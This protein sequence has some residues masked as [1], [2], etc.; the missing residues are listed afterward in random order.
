M[1]LVIAAA[2]FLCFV[3]LTVTT[4]PG[5]LHA[6]AVG[7]PDNVLDRI[8]FRLIGPNAPS[9]RVWNVAGVPSRPKAFYVCTAQGGVFRTSN[10]GTTMEPVF[11]QENAASC[12]A[13]AIA[14]SDPQCIWVGSGEPAARQSNGLGY[15]AYKSTDGGKTWQFLGL[16]NTEQIAAIA[17]HPRDPQ[18][19]WLAAMG[20]LWGRNAERGVFKT[21]DGGRTWR[22]VL[23][24][25]DM[26]G[27]I[28]IA[29]DPQ[30]PKILYASMWQRLR[31]GGAEMRESGPGSGIHKSTDG[32]ETWV[33]LTKGLPE[34]PLSKITLAVSQKTPGLVYAYILSGEAGRGGRTSAAGGVFRSA[35]GGTSWQ[36]VS[37][38]LASRTYYTHIKIDPNNDDRLWILDLE[39]WR[40]D[41]GG[42]NW[43]KHNMKHVH[44]DLHGLWIDPNDSDHLVL[45]GDAGVVVSNDDGQSWFQ[46]VLPLAQFYEVDVDNQE[47]YW[48]YGGMQDTASWSGPSRTYDNE[49]ITDHDWIKLRSTGDGMAIHPDPRDPNIILLAQNNGNLS[50][51]DL[52]TW[53]R[54]EL[55]PTQ[56]EAQ[57]MGLRPLR[58]DWSPPFFLSSSNHDIIYLGAQYVFEC[59]IGQT[60]PN[61]EVS[62][63]CRAISQDLTAQQDQ[64][65]P[66]VGEGYHSYGAL[67][68]LAQSPV[69][70]EA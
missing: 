28:D 31:S 68:S 4:S 59:R 36:R 45:A 14:P 24:L 69:S 1:R 41:D 70:P 21:T 23:Y 11:D 46:T 50:R 56:T 47:P 10:N 58:W 54:T 33:R 62:R 42:R 66:L 53:T 57:Q 20:H 48:V 40:S 34:E 60:L 25:D 7:P 16:E 29:L 44:D 63:A 6:Q 8:H 52:R 43:V 27:C 17:I 64:P 18:I 61:G 35:D 65:S 38:K 19:V 13:V 32:G 26:T 2:V 12:G 22:K 51:L 55:Q 9:G 39:L 30:D 37:P 49:G 3:A 5:L 15:G 67:F